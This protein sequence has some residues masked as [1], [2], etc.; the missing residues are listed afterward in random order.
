MF[1][2]AISRKWIFVGSVTFIGLAGAASTQTGL[3]RAVPG[4]NQIIRLASSLTGSR[5]G[6]IPVQRS[7]SEQ[8]LVDRDNS[9]WSV[10][11]TS[12]AATRERPIFSPSRQPRPTAVKANPLQTSPTQPPLML[13]GAIAGEV[14]GIAIFQDKTT[15]S[16]VR[17]KPG[18]SHA[19][20]I[21]KTVKAREVTLQNEQRG[22]ILTLPTPSA[23]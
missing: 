13:V 14:E 4:L 1:S 12:L 10:P 23:K 2:V 15:K 19:G 20:W 16:I 18:E 6:T 7:G 9:L 5:A 21:L 17:L 3:E 8:G 22:A 11:L